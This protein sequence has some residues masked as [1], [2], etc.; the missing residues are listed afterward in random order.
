MRSHRFT[1]F[2]LTLSVALIAAAPAAAQAVHE[3]HGSEAAAAPA[4]QPVAPRLQNLGNYHHAI[5]TK[6]PRAQQFFDQGL[7]LSYG[8]NHAEAFRAFAEAARLDPNCAMCYWGQA[9]VLGPN[10][11]APMNPDDEPRALELAQKALALKPHASE[12]ER[13][14]IDALATR[15]SGDAK[16][17]KTRDHAYAEAM[18]K[19]A[20]R[21]PNDLDAVTLHA[22]AIMDLR[23]WN[24]WTRDGLPYPETKDLVPIL[25][26]VLRRD[27][28]HP[29]AI[30]LYIHVTEDTKSP[31]RAVPYA[32][33]LADL[34]P[35]AGHIVHMPSHT[36]MRVGQY[37]KAVASNER[38]VLADED[39][40][41]QCRAQGLYPLGY[42]P[43]N[44]H[45][46]WWAASA[47]GRSQLA[48]DSARKAVAQFNAD[49]VHQHPFLQ[50]FV[51]IPYFVY[52][53][54]GQWDEMLKQP[55]PPMGG[56][57][58]EGIWHY[59]RGMAFSAKG[60]LD[61]ATA[62]LEALKRIATDPAI[63][64]DL[65]SFSSNRASVI[66]S[67]AVEALAGELAGRRGENE[68]AIAH[69][70]RAVLLEE[71]L[72][73]T[74][75]A[76]WPYPMR[77]WLGAALIQAGRPV[78]AEAV[79]WEDLQK[80]PENGWSLF[81]LAQA[82][83]AQGKTDQAAAIEAR[84]KQAWARADVQLSASRF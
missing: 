12:P 22:E 23:P 9:L 8:F 51:V 32:D 11:N 36:Y 57:F 69:L 2:L 18:A 62:E 15:Y 59:A 80:N 25:E 75:P 72:V 37:D 54:F 84:F 56:K 63:D 41:S 71:S 55:Q 70:H 34:M 40:I 35:A 67:V 39:Y 3:S 76:A 5:T 65:V 13:A 16:D 78:E 58:T 6:I 30:H 4:D 26:S 33:K 45:F 53:R 19:L 74:E 17:R 61:D 42:Y 77:Q 44:I 31:E 27:P 73:Y 20:Q 49:V 66:L 14:Y 50:S 43:H 60:K 1:F 28:N 47:E 38:A 68:S 81:G 21:Y 29:G 79:Y 24:Y 82:L 46:L 10:I 64:A 7:R 52:V 83:R 48:L